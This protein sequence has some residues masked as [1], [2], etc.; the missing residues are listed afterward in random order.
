MKYLE[1]DVVW[2]KYSTLEG[3]LQDCP[4]G[5]VI[6][7]PGRLFA[8]P[9]PREGYI[10]PWKVVCKTAPQGGFSLLYDLLPGHEM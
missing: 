3:C 4:P 9:P 5:R 2:L 6:F 7:N 1:N 10:Q 8:R